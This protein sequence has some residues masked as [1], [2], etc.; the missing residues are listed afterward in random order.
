MT[1]SGRGALH[2]LRTSLDPDTAAFYAALL[3]G[4]QRLL[5]PAW[6]EHLARVG[7]SHLLSIGGMHLGF[8]SMAVF[9]LVRF[10]IRTFRPSILQHTSDRMLAL[11]PALAAAVLYA[12]VAGF[13]VP[14]IW[15]STLMLTL[16]LTAACSYRSPDQLSVLAAAALVILAADPNSLQQISFQLTFACMFAIFTLYPRFESLHLTKTLP[17]LSRTRRFRGFCALSRKPSGF[18]SP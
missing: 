3:L 18:P 2:W 11:W 1:G 14:P 13:S 16:C 9:W 5:S 15:R 6:Q 10:L 17:V 12:L 7:V 4:Y 8:F